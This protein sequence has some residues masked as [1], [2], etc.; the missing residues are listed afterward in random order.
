MADSESDWIKR[1]AYTLWEEEGYPSGKDL[2]H[3]ERAKLEFATQKP[4]ASHSAIE[5]VGASA[6]SASTKAISAKGASAKA[7]SAKGKAS[8]GS[9]DAGTRAAVAPKGTAAKTGAA[10]GN[11]RNN[12]KGEAAPA[13]D[14]AGDMAT[15]AAKAEKPSLAKSAK[16]STPQVSDPVAAAEIAPKKRSRKATAGA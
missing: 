10:K 12:G 1:R 9:K 2:E 8:D 14:I 11:G 3:W 5:N 16:K 7:A 6:P 15:K 4:T 13:A